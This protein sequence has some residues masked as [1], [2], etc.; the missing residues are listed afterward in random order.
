MQ[1][2]A[3]GSGLETIWFNLMDQGYADK[4]FKFIELDL[5]I[6]V[7]RKIRKI[8]NSKKI[9]QLFERLK[10]QPSIAGTKSHT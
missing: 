3:L 7:K 2:V 1:I 5:D 8:K 4:P 9:N 6:V 10:L